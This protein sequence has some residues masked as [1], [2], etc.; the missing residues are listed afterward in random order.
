MRFLILIYILLPIQALSLDVGTSIKTYQS[1]LEQTID[2]IK[3]T[4]SG[5]E[6][7]KNAEKLV[8]TSKII[9][10]A[11]AE[12]DRNCKNYIKKT[13]AAGQKMLS[14][15]LDKIELDYHQDNALPEAP[16][17]CHHAKDLLV[18]P[19]TVYILATKHIGE[20]SVREKMYKELVELSAH[21]H[22]TSINI[23]KLNKL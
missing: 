11:Y 17:S 7:S 14:M 1:V 20:K 3:G 21:L 8:D 18:H 15:K 6:I 2:G 12:K 23:K 19:A 10:N 5:E 22:H 16:A 4:M 13:L 9:L